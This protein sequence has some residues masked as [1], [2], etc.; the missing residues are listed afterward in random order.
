MRTRRT[1]AGSAA[2]WL[3]GPG[4][5]AWGQ[6]STVGPIVEQEQALREQRLMLD[7]EAYRWRI[8]PLELEEARVL[9]ERFRREWLEGRR[10][11][12]AS[13]GGP[14]R[15][16]GSVRDPGAREW[17]EAPERPRPAPP[18]AD[19]SAEVPARVDARLERERADLRAR[20]QQEEAE[21]ARLRQRSRTL[22]VT[23]G[24]DQRWRQRG[25]SEDGAR[26]LQY[27]ILRPG[28]R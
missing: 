6:P 15:E 8:G 2:L 5:G 25:R 12:G 10:P 16:G 13:A 22:G 23:P 27:D 21:E 11:S 9:R 17:L 20:V 24:E 26:E 14:A 7:Q 3:L 28:V 1:I 19:G 4:A 18:P